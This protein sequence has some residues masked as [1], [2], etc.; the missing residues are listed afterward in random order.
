MD[1]KK[2]EHYIKSLDDSYFKW[3]IWIINFKLEDLASKTKKIRFIVNNKLTKNKK[4]KSLKVVD[5][6]NKDILLALNDAIKNDAS[7]RKMLV[8]DIFENFLLH[9]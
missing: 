7:F 1:L 4:G 8:Q 3:G 2:I 9:V 6:T 5:F